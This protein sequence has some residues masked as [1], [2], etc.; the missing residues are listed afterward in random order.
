MIYTDNP[1][2]QDVVDLFEKGSLHVNDMR[3]FFAESVCEI[4]DDGMTPM[5]H[6]DAA[7]SIFDRWYRNLRKTIWTNGA[8]YALA[9]SSPHPEEAGKKADTM[10][11]KAYHNINK[12]YH[13][14]ACNEL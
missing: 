9:G 2:E 8:E 3:E 7:L 10:Y 14:R 12:K 5:R 13:N 11:R 6:Y 4:L 1:L